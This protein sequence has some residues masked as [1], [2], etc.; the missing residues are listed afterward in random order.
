M[1]RPSC[2]AALDP[3][4]NKPDGTVARALRLIESRA[5][6]GLTV[7]EVASVLRISRQAL[8]SMPFVKDLAADAGANAE[9]GSHGGSGPRNFSP[10]PN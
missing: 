8:Q 7:K 3:Q 1:S 4:G 10:A 5:C 9:A 6:D 2:N